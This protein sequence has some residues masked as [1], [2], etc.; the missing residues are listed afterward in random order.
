M[1]VENPFR[2]TQNQQ[3][4]DAGTVE[5]ALWAVP[6]PMP[7]SQQISLQDG[8]WAR[9]AAILEASTVTL[10]ARFSCLLPSH[11]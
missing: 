5:K 9:R 6:L 7:V 3:L 8:P 2:L 11:F 1:K 4:E 10:G